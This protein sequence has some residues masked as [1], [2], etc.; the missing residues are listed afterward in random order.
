KQPGEVGGID[1][2]L[3]GQPFLPSRRICSPAVR[4]VPDLPPPY[5]REP[6]QQR[7]KRLLNHRVQIGVVAVPP[8]YFVTVRDPVRLSARPRFISNEAQNV[9]LLALEILVGI[10]IGAQ[11]RLV[12]LPT[13]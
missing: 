10:G 5:S 6:R 1:E 8:V 2:E 4:L 13:L 12:P 11:E 3:A 9:Q 7:P